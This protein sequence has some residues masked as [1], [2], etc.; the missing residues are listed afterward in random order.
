MAENEGPRK[1][2]YGG[3]IPW[4]KELQPGDWVAPLALI[5]RL[6]EYACHRATCNL[7]NQSAWDE[8]ALS[9]ADL[10]PEVRADPEEMSRVA[11][12]AFEIA[13]KRVK[14]TCGLAALL[15]EIDTAR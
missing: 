8:A 12:A 4:L 10:P 14:C 9:L 2:G 1:D 11:Q 7:N 15:F 13:D 3:E 5:W 6:R